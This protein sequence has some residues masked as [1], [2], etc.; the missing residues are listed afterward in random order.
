M[1]TLPEAAQIMS[2]PATTFFN[3]E[4]LRRYD[5]P[6]FFLGGGFLAGLL[7]F[8]VWVSAQPDDDKH[9]LRARGN[10]IVGA[11]AIAQPGGSVLGGITGGTPGA[12]AA[13]DAH[14]DSYFFSNADEQDQSGEGEEGALAPDAAFDQS[15]VQES[16]AMAVGEDVDPQ[17][18]PEQG[19]LTDSL[20]DAPP[21]APGAEA[22]QAPAPP[23]P[24]TGGA[25][26]PW[27]VEVEVAPGQ[28]QMLQLN[29]ESPEHALAILR[30]FR[31]NPRVLRGPSP[32]PLP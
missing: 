23:A 7:I 31:G 19:A 5:G 10:G 15:V 16:D 21:A 24:E 25:L 22:T 11:Q 32:E 17:P 14:D 29:A 8:L 12:G 4:R 28:V 6:E 20:L 9:R 2:V 27:F 26:R 30:D 18:Y 3:V 13:D 1:R